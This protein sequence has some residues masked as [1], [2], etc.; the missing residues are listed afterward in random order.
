LGDWKS[1]AV[2]GLAAFVAFPTVTAYSDI[3]S[4]ISGQGAGRAR[5]EA[6][7]TTAPAGSV[8]SA[9][10]TFADP[11]LT[12]SLS[13]SA[14]VTLPDGRQVA[15]SGK[16]GAPETTPDE[17]RVTRAEKQ[18]RVLAVAPMLPPVNFS[19]GSLA[20]KQTSALETVVGSSRKMAFVRSR[21]E[22]E[23]VQIASAFYPQAPLPKAGPERMLADLVTNQQPDILAVAYADAEPDYARNSPF[24]SILTDDNRQGRF[25][26]PAPLDDPQHAWVATPLPASVFKADQQR[27]LAAAVY[28]E[29]RGEPIKG[30]AAVAQVVLNRVRNPSYP[31]TICGVVYQNED[32]RHRCQFSFACDGLRERITDRMHWKIAEQVAMAVTAGKIW[33]NDVGSSTHYHAVYVHPGWARDMKKV[34]RIGRHV[35]YETFNGGWD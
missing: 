8:Q 7:L 26:P 10:M 1:T 6:H 2:F 28:F 12:G 17:D 4:L 27:C 24:A 31:A 32:W 25:V 16:I 5:W 3:A 20:G 9:E 14:G 34:D 11:I 29:A 21:I 33:L 35:F 23:E 18:G 13:P 15:F 22:G 19:A 30:Q